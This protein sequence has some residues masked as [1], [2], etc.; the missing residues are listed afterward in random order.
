MYIAGTLDLRL[1]GL[2]KEL[3]LLSFTVMPGAFG[4]LDGW[5]VHDVQPERLT[6]AHPCLD[7][8]RLAQDGVL[9]EGASGVMGTGHREY[10]IAAHEGGILIAGTFISMRSHP[11]NGR[12][13]VCPRCGRGC[14]RIYEIDGWA[15]RTCHRLDYSSRHRNRTVPGLSRLT[16][17]RRSIGEAATPFSLIAPRSLRA[18]KFW[19]IVREIRWLEAGLVKHAQI[20]VCE[21]L[22]R[23]IRRKPGS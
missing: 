13:F 15:C 17:L 11:L 18:R 16:F 10:Q 3:R 19:R 22:E 2:T 8:F 20:D 1:F 14:Y 7:C 9:C 12:N 4:L 21:A 5:H 6:N 23:R